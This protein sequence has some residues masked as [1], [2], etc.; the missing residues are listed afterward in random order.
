LNAIIESQIAKVSTGQNA[1]QI[2]MRKIIMTVDSAHMGGIETHVITLTKYLSEQGYQVE[3]WFFDKYA[4]NPTYGLLEEHKI[5]FRFVGTVKN[6][7]RLVKAQQKDIIVHTHGYK[8]GIVGR[9]VAKLLGVPVLSTYHSG[10]L[11]RGKLR[12]YSYLDLWTARLGQSIAVSSV[13]KGWLPSSAKLIPNFISVGAEDKNSRSPHQSK[14]LQVAFVGRL[15]HEKGPDLFCRLAGLWHNGTGKCIA[16]NAKSVEFVLYGDG[17]DRTELI[18]RFNQHVQFKGHVNMK[19]CWADVD[20]LCISSRFEGL[21]Y[22]ALEAMGQ[23]IPVISFD[24]G[25]IGKLISDP[26][27]GWL[28]EAGNMA[29]LKQAIENWYGL[30]DQDRDV[31]AKNVQDKI[32]QQYSS[33]ALVP[34][35]EA[36][37][38]QFQRQYS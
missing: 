21:P 37:Y 26:S 7:W 25:G 29:A 38:Q 24:V 28:V 32:R 30:S 9:F 1:E 5:S 20:V 33:E 14:V 10:D 16:S 12:L 35:I 3:V 19:E 4:N 8:A 11:G 18:Q 23:G 34:S 17:P 13:I 6:F 15:S 2:N 36:I 31:L 27:L 22:V